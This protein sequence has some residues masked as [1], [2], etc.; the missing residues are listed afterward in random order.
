MSRPPIACFHTS[1]HPTAP[2]LSPR[3]WPS[4]P[5][6]TESATKLS[7]HGGG[8]TAV[9]G[10]GALVAGPVVATGGAAVVTTAAAVVDGGGGA[11]GAGTSSGV[12]AAS[13]SGAS[14]VAAVAVM[15]LL[16]RYRNRL[17]AIT[18][19]AVAVHSQSLV[20]TKAAPCAAA[21]SRS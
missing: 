20:G 11:V 21:T 18:G 13:S 16:S 9:V 3:P 12:T 17:S 1:W 10:G 6:P 8:V 5:V 19:Q 2:R 4:R 7:A 15:W 14:H